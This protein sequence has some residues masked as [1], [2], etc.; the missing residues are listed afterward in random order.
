MKR[1]NDEKNRYVKLVEKGTPDYKFVI[2]ADSFDPGNSGSAPGVGTSAMVASLSLVHL[3]C[4]MPMVT[5]P[6]R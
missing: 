1:W 5:A 6:A 4:L 2:K 3:R